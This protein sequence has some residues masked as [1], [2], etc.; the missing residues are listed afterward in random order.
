VLPTEKSDIIKEIQETGQITAF[1][2]DGI[3]DAP[4]LKQAM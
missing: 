2:G 1:V 4:A 3:N